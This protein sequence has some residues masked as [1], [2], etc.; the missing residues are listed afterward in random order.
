[1]YDLKQFK[2]IFDPILNKLVDRKI[3]E[4]QKNTKDSFV[5]DFVIYSKNLITGGGKRIRP[6]ITYLTYKSFGG[7]SEK[8]IMNI[9]ISLEL[10]HNFC[11][12]HDD[13]MDKGKARHGQTTIHEFV[14]EKLKHEKRIG[15]LEHIA[16]SQ[17][18]LIGDVIY[19]WV[20]ELFFE[21]KN[22]E[23]LEIAKQ[24]FYKMVDEVIMGQII[25][26]NLVSMQNPSYDLIEEK[27][28]LKTSRYS[29]VR[30][31]QIGAI[32]A[33]PNY[34]QDDLFETLG[35]KLGIAF[36]IQ[37]DLLDIMGRQ[38]N[39]QK[40]PLLDIT[41]HQHT[42]FTYFV[43]NKGTKDQKQYLNEVFGKKVFINEDK[44]RNLF[45]DSGALDQGKKIIDQNFN[46]AKKL[47]ENS[48]IEDKYKEKMLELIE[49]MQQR[50][51]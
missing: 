33:N 8:E 16:N 35:T 32:L 10:F 24:Y 29:F 38:N 15:D 30:P 36:Q 7:K 40:T 25:D 50:Q 9:L 17:A 49:L 45:I 18:I 48:L 51:S 27:T 4:F 12:I 46:E 34:G 13:V 39:L 5:K 1:M 22:L 26:I 23:N 2:E 3:E 31:M 28:R 19:S 11:L 43:L 41:Q 21:N 37:D 44:I 14:L 6:Y 42:F 20:I 47:V